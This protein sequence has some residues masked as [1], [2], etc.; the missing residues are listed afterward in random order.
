MCSKAGITGLVRLVVSFALLSLAALN[1]CGPAKQLAYVPPLGFVGSLRARTESLVD[2]VSRS[3]VI[4]IASCTEI[5]EPRN[6]A[7]VTVAGPGGDTYEPDPNLLMLDQVYLLQVERYLK[8]SGPDR[9][10]F[11]Q[12]EGRLMGTD[13]SPQ[14]FE[15]ARRDSDGLPLLQVGSRYILFLRREV[16]AETYMRGAGYPARFEL[17]GGEA[18]PQMPRGM[19]P[20][21]A[22]LTRQPEAVLLANVEDYVAGKLPTPVPSPTSRPT[23]PTATVR[24]ESPAAPVRAGQA[25]T[26]PLTIDTPSPVWALEFRL[27]YD[28]SLLQLE[29]IREGDFFGSWAQANRCSTTVL[30]NASGQSGGTPIPVGTSNAVAILLL[31]S[32]GTGPSGSGTVF[33]LRFTARASGASS[34]TLS[35]VKITRVTADKDRNVDYVPVSKSDARVTVSPN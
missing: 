17:A 16:L 24:L 31:G 12:L 1:A 15:T 23:P 26:V 19:D 10:R 18:L 8:G 4:A 25:F 30:G 7:Y 35:S 3:E 29:E 28:E 13:R 21:T 32:S 9:V 2:L 22:G 27:Q 14:A 20:A 33:T 34:V 11:G 6:G 5:A